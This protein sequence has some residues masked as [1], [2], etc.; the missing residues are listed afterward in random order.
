MKVGTPEKIDKNAVSRDFTPFFQTHILSMGDKQGRMFEM[1]STM[2][3][4]PDSLLSDVFDKLMRDKL[5]I[6][7]KVGWLLVLFFFNNLIRTIRKST[8]NVTPG[9]CLKASYIIW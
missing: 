9:I 8:C 1:Y 5:I 2:R 6:R 3:Q 7:P 4:Y